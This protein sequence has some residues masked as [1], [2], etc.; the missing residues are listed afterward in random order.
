MKRISKVYNFGIMTVMICLILLS[1]DV[2]YSFPLPKETLRLQIGMQD[3]TFDRLRIFLE[4]QKIFTFLAERNELPSRNVPADLLILFGNDD[5]K[6]IE[7]AAGVYKDGLVNN[8]VVSGGRGRLA[9]PLIEHAQKE[10]YA[11]KGDLGV[12]SEAEIMKQLLINNGVPEDKIIIEDKSTNTKENADNIKTKLEEKNFLQWTAVIMQVPLQQRR[13]RLTF[14]KTFEKE[15]ASGD[16][17]YMSYAPYVPDV[18]KMS[19]EELVDSISLCMK[20]FE[21]FREYGP[22]GKNHMRE[23]E[24]DNEVQSAYDYAL[25][26]GRKRMLPVEQLSRIYSDRPSLFSIKHSI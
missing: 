9:E 11:I 4:L 6:T 12:I 20:E 19:P 24:I 14:E 15:I 21:R 16:V 7:K 25:L 13:A 2:L 26:L 3:D 1:T 18:V 5:I 17:R 8:I 22:N 23:A 10:E